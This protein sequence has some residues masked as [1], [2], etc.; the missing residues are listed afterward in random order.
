MVFYSKQTMAL[1]KDGDLNACLYLP[2][3]EIPPKWKFIKK[4]PM[5]KLRE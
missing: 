4:A 2:P 5:P 3:S 1:A